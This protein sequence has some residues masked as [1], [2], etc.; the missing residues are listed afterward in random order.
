MTLSKLAKLANVSVST[1]SKA[2]SGSNEV[3]EETRE[4]VFEVAK[5]YGCFKKFYNAKYPK[6]VIAVIVP[7]VKS[8]YYAQHISCLQEYLENCEICISTT[9]FSAETETNLIEYYYQHSQ[10]DG[11]IV[12]DSRLKTIP[13]FEIPL[14]SINSH[15]I[16]PCSTSRKNSYFNALSEA[17]S[18]LMSRNVTTIGFIGERLTS[19]KLNAFRQVLSQEGI[20]PNEDHIQ[21]TDKRFE[22]G[23]YEAMEALFSRGTLPRSLI[24]AYDN[25]AIG[26]IRCI[27]DH[28]LSVPNDIAVLGT[29]NIANAAFLN[30]PLASISSK[31]PE[32][33]RT[34]ANTILCLIQGKAVDAPTTIAAEFI[35]RRSFEI[36]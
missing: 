27:H 35:M 3:N 5:Q 21:I 2:F 9:D 28:G 14:V 17:V 11:I 8:L 20:T 36:D 26:A 30:P 7:E 10:V 15:E 13:A 16:S 6:L 4:I 32:V 24:C 33:C 1:A 18:Y 29:D 23:G 34:A 22:E 31:V 12:V 25:M 19:Y